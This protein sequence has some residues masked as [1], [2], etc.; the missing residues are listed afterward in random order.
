MDDGFLKV[1][2]ELAFAYVGKNGYGSDTAEIYAYHLMPYSPLLLH[3]ST[4]SDAQ[5]EMGAIA[6]RRMVELCTAFS[7]VM[8]CNLEFE[9]SKYTPGL[10]LEEWA[11]F[12]GCPFT[13]RVHVRVIPN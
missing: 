6:H 1:W 11:S 8:D 4:R 2:S 9:P 12:E 13:H 7:R 3:D 10:S 5:M